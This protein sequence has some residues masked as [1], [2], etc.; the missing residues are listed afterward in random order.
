MLNT[1][2]LAGYAIYTHDAVKIAAD[3]GGIKTEPELVYPKKKWESYMDLITES[4]AG[5]IGRAAEQ[6]RSIQVSPPTV[7]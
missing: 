6:T 4:A 7:R 5:A 3:L 1:V 2:T